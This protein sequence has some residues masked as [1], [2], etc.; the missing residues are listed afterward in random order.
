MAAVESH[1][2]H[3]G[4]GR[5]PTRSTGDVLN[6]PQEPPQPDTPPGMPAES[7]GI[8]V[9]PLLKHLDSPASPDTHGYRITPEILRRSALRNGNDSGGGYDAGAELRMFQQRALLLGR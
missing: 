4:N 9:N 6:S 3:S 7:S 8:P 1:G 2:E 5:S